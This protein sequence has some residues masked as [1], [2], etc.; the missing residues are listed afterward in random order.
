MFKDHAL[1]NIAVQQMSVFLV[2]S[3]INNKAISSRVAVALKLSQL[4]LYLLFIT[5][6]TEPSRSVTKCTTVGHRMSGES[7]PSSKKDCQW[8][9]TSSKED[10]TVT[11]KFTAFD[12]SKSDPSCNKDYVEIRNGLTKHAPLIG[13]Y[14]GDK[15]PAP[16]Q[17][18]GNGLWVRY[19]VSGDIKTNVGMTYH[20]GPY[21]S[22]LV[23]EGKKGMFAM[24]ISYIYR[25]FGS[26]CK[27]RI[28]R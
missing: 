14:C 21:K 8:H 27:Y 3:C 18:S 16:V 15:M 11:L 13:R 4:M 28:H 24:E 20:D 19:V 17:S 6:A 5:Y 22:S 1:N 7:N 9:V 25:V 26:I 2:C 23:D 12:F 10:G